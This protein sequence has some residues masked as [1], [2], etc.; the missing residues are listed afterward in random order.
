MNEQLDTT[1]DDA[2]V[3]AARLLQEP[4]GATRQR[5]I[6]LARLP[7]DEEATARDIEAE[8][9]LTRI[10]TGILAE[11][12]AT[13]MVTIQCM[14]CLEDFD[15]PVRPTFAD[16]YRPTVDIASGEEVAPNAGG[17]DEA[18]Y[19][20]IDGAHLLDLSEGLRQA[21]VLALPMAP[22]CREDCPGLVEDEA[23]ASEAGD[24]RLAVLGQLLGAGGEDTEEYAPG[25]EGARRRA[26]S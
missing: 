18:E 13:A 8:V 16:E 25:R 6:A 9:K 2:R 15:Q 3:H 11:G 14:R 5:S 19:F 23:G 17:V 26:T 12:R 7:L 20:T 22:R 24:G 21:I 4:V 10:P 1:G